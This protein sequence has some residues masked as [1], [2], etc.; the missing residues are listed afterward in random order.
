[1]NRIMQI[2]GYQICVE[3][4]FVVMCF[5]TLQKVSGNT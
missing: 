1:M 2:L 4:G 5:V 3:N